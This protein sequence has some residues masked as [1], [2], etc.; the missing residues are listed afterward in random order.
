MKDEL[1]EIKA[2][3]LQALSEGKEPDI[4]SLQNWIEENE[5]DELIACFEVVVDL[6]GIYRDEFDEGMVDFD[7][8]EGIT[9]E[10]RMTYLLELAESCAGEREGGGSN[11]NSRYVHYHEMSLVAGESICVACNLESGPFGNLT[12]YW[13]DIYGT[14]S[15]EV[16]EKL[17]AQG[18]YTVSSIEKLTWAEVEK[19]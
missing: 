3:I 10:D 15:D 2:H 6:A 8:D 1:A 14:S 17:E 7:E 12:I 19:V 5:I 13:D 18:L 16:F 9:D 11:Y 4:F